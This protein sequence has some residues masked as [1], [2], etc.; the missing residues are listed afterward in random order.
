MKCEKCGSEKIKQINGLTDKVEHFCLE[1]GTVQKGS[2]AELKTCNTCKY[3][4]QAGEYQPQE[5]R[6][7]SCTDF[8]K[9]QLGT[10]ASKKIDKAEM[11]RQITTDMS[12][13]YRAKN[14]DYGDSFAKSIESHGLIAAVVRLEDKMNRIAS[15]VKSGKA[16]VKTETIEDTLVDLANY[17][18]MTVIEMRLKK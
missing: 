4:K 16:E 2:Q 6:C 10:F 12:D 14:K 17:A 1:C 5:S 8:D 13:I 3:R 18:V 11:H 9:W 7:F 15:L